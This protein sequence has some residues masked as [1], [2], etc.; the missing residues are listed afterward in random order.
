[1]VTRRMWKPE[2]SLGKA[3]IEPIKFSALQVHIYN[4]IETIELYDLYMNAGSQIDVRW[5]IKYDSASYIFAE[6]AHILIL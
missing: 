5:V 1:M 3:H 2:F 6:E 4:S